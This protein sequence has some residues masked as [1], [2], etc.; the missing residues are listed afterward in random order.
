MSFP[1]EFVQPPNEEVEKT[2]QKM[3]IPAAESNEE[4]KA[5]SGEQKK[6]RGIGAFLA[7]TL[8][9]RL[10]SLSPNPPLIFFLIIHPQKSVPKIQS[11]EKVPEGKQIA[12]NPKEHPAADRGP[13]K[14]KDDG[15]DP[16]PLRREKPEEFQ[17]PYCGY[18][19][20]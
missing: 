16:F 1:A 15:G 5:F 18:K 13:V 17:C 11:L 6:A 12:N 14:V 3:S 19:L 10:F 20:N 4:V 9:L 8:L 2:G 7:M